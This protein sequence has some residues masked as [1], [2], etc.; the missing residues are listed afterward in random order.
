MRRSYPCTGDDGRS[1]YTMSILPARSEQGNVQLRL[2]RAEAI[3]RGLTKIR[4]ELQ[5]VRMEWKENSKAVDDMIG[6]NGLAIADAVQEV[7]KAR[8]HLELA[9]HRANK[10]T[11]R[12]PEAAR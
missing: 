9:H 12:E 8:T 1:W 7:A 3:L 11:G 10:T 4:V 6:L 2:S 5:R